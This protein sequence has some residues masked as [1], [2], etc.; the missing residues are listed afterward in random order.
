MTLKHLHSFIS[1]L[2]TYVNLFHNSLMLKMWWTTFE[3]IFYTWDNS[4]LS[5][6]LNWTEMI[7]R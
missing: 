1:I 6:I 3:Q 2:Q 7:P 5:V 4:R